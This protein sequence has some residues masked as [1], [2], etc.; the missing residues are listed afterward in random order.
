MNHNDPFYWRLILLVEKR[1]EKTCGAFRFPIFERFPDANE[2]IPKQAT[3]RELD[4]EVMKS[5]F[6]FSVFDG[7]DPVGSAGKNLRNPQK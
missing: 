5:A 4:T 1:G 6:P 7:I 3:L 2:S